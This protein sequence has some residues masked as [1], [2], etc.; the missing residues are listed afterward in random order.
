MT[1]QASIFL[2]VIAVFSARCFAGSSDSEATAGDERPNILFGIMDDAS[3]QHMSAYGCT[4][5]DTPGFDRL[6][7]EGLL[8]KN[9]YTP[10]AKCAPSRSVVLTGRN[11]WQ[12][13]EAA[14]HV[15]NF[16]A[17]FKTFPEAPRAHG[18]ITGKT[19]KG[20]GPGYPGIL[21]GE[22]R[23]LVGKSWENQRQQAPTTQIMMV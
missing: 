9:A 20:W 8:F 6:A 16:P 19:G 2:I 14:N 12:L 5:V 21:D 1:K 18:Y 7:R 17:K 23:L 11:S 3:M 22:P 13:E 4:W 15:V 10:N